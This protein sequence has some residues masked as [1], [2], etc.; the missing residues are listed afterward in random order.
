MQPTLLLSDGREPIRTTTKDSEAIRNTLSTIA[1]AVPPDALGRIVALRLAQYGYED[2]HL[3]GTMD[4]HKWGEV[5]KDWIWRMEPRQLVIY[6]ET[7][8]QTNRFDGIQLL[9]EVA[10]GEALALM[11]CM[12]QEVDE[13]ETH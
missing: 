8:R 5:F 3:R 9:M 11:W 6:W 7:A 4:V 13:D 2:P 1:A 12:T 10:K